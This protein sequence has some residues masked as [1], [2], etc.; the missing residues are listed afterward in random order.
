M[1]DDS[2]VGVLD[3]ATR[4]LTTISANG[5]ILGTRSLIAAAGAPESFCAL[6][7]GRLLLAS[8][9][10]DSLVEV[11][12]D[13]TILGARRKPFDVRDPSGLVSQVIVTGAGADCAALLYR[14]GGGTLHRAA[15]DAA[16]FSFVSGLE[17]PEWVLDS[18]GSRALRPAAA[19]IYWAS[20]ADDVVSTLVWR[21]DDQPREVIDEYD[22]RDGGYRRSFRLPARA[23]YFARV[24]DSIFV[25]LSD[26]NDALTLHALI[27]RPRG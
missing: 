21:S 12:S 7:D 6:G 17:L 8:Y 23:S 18:V 4:R 5:E 3:Q 15:G 14:G 27:L 24:R 26:S 13:G 19:A 1:L 9:G 25:Q 20:F 22:A 10:R 11:G 16:D 2:T